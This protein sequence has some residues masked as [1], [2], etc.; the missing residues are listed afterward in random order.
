MAGMGPGEGSIEYNIRQDS[1]AQRSV[2]LCAMRS[3]TPPLWLNPRNSLPVILGVAR[4]DP[5]L[6]RFAAELEVNEDEARRFT[7]DFQE[8][9]QQFRTVLQHELHLFQTKY[10]ELQCWEIAPEPKDAGSI[11]NLTNLTHADLDI[12]VTLNNGRG[13]AVHYD[14]KTKQAF[15]PN[16]KEPI[17]PAVIM[18]IID[19]FHRAVDSLMKS[20]DTPKFQELERRKLGKCQYK[21][22]ATTEYALGRLEFDLLPGFVDITGAYCLLDQSTGSI[23]ISRN[24]NIAYKMENLAKDFQGIREFIKTLKLVSKAEAIQNPGIQNAKLSSHLYEVI[25]MTVLDQKGTKWWQ[26]TSFTDITRECLT[27]LLDLLSQESPFTSHIDQAWDMLANAKQHRNQVRE[28]LE[29]W[30]ALPAAS[31]LNHLQ[32]CLRLVNAGSLAVVDQMHVHLPPLA[33]TPTSSIDSVHKSSQFISQSPIQLIQFNA[34][35]AMQITSE[36]RELLHSLR[37]K[38]L[39]IIGMVGKFRSAKSCFLNRRDILLALLEYYVVSINRNESAVFE[40]AWTKAVKQRCDLALSQAKDFFN[41]KIVTIQLPMESFDLDNLVKEIGSQAAKLIEEALAG[42]PIEDLYFDTLRTVRL[43]THD[44]LT[45]ENL[46]KS[47]TACQ[48]TLQPRIAEILSLTGRFR[49]ENSLSPITNLAEFDAT[50]Q[51]LKNHYD[52]TC[53]G[54]AKQVCWTDTMVQL[55]A[56]RNTANQVFAERDRAAA[57]VRAQQR[58]AN[59]QRNYYPPQ[60]TRYYP[61]NWITPSP[62]QR[63]FESVDSSSDDVEECGFKKVSDGQPCTRLVR[64]GEYCWQHDRKRP[65]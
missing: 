50:V 13:N 46:E 22:C 62:P 63:E 15:W 14:A 29:R 7:R 44:A 32:Q 3:A 1:R 28:F 48:S 19:A 24:E 31:M 61:N 55:N 27:Y 9:F 52:N 17:Q 8:F 25:T 65:R 4:E 2:L 43:S 6:W 60:P 49:A 38:A 37:G 10:P 47:R 40:T 26:K 30:K 57:A 51:A 59:I 56:V 36:G 54:P 11:R 58:A 34:E 21:F 16:S 53:C 23:L 64:V 12:V 42:I 18:T 45:R 39:S 33:V 35:A 20:A 5:A 41:S